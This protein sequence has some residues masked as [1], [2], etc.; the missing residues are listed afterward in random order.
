MKTIGNTQKASPS[1]GTMQSFGYA[2]KAIGSDAN[3]TAASDEYCSLFQKY[4]SSV[5][6]T[7][8]R[9]VILP[10][11]AGA[12]AFIWNATSG[13]QAL[14]VISGGTGITIGS[15]KGAWVGCDGTNWVRLSADVTP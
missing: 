7:A 14:R 9:D 15:L 10:A 3:Y 12:I 2:A 4:T 13:S 11:T 6:W 8:T 1:L 5:N